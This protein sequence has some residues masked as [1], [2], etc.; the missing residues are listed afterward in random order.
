MVGSKDCYLERWLAT[1][2]ACEKKSARTM[3]RRRD[4]KLKR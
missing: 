4:G 1:G 2:M 3:A